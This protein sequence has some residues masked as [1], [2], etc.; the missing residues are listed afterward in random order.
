LLLILGGFAFGH[1]FF[2]YSSV[3]SASREAARWGAA[4]GE[5]PSALPR[6]QDCA[7]I[8]AVSDSRLTV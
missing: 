4:V 2:V 1:M 3:V 6:Y 5:A 7:S 8:R